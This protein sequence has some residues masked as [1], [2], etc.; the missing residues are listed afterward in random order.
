MSVPD[1]ILN[2]FRWKAGALIL[3]VFVWFLINFAIS[4]GV[5]PSDRTLGD[6][7]EQTFIEQTVFVLTPP[8]D[9]RIFKVTPPKV[10][11]TIRSTALALNRLGKADIRAF[12]DLA[13]A[14]NLVSESREV[15]VKTPDGIEISD[16]RVKPSAVTVERMALQK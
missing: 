1:F 14:T 10:D 7:R 13:D 3:A 15:L 8:G 16:I 2:N 12:V 6:M 5:K 9:L 11:I 4:K